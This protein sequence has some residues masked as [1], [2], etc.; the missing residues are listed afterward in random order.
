LTPAPILNWAAIEFIDL[1]FSLSNENFTLSIDVWDVFPTGLQ[2]NVTAISSS[3]FLAPFRIS[4]ITCDPSH[5]YLF[6]IDWFEFYVN[7]AND[8]PAY[9]TGPM[10]ITTTYPAYLIGYNTFNRSHTF[11]CL[12]FI[13]TFNL[14]NASGFYDL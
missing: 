10:N 9:S 11:G 3:Y 12:T 5:P 6:A 2:I 1:S 4:Y 8:V 14:F 7:T 13:N